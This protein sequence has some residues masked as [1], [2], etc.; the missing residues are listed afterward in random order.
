MRIDTKWRT[1]PTII[2]KLL[3]RPI[4]LLHQMKVGLKINLI[5]VS[6]KSVKYKVDLIK[7]NMLYNARKFNLN[8]EEVMWRL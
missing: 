5:K 6:S 1:W 8:M 2:K 3:I 4:C 7:L